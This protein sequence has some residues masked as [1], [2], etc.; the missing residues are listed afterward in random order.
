MLLLCSERNERLGLCVY[1][2]ASCIYRYPSLLNELSWKVLNMSQKI[3][4]VDDD[5]MI[6]QMMS[7]LLTGEGYEVIS[8]STALTDFE[9][10]REVRPNLII[11][12]FMMYGKSVGFSLIEKLKLQKDLASIPL[13]VCTG[14]VKEVG[15]LEGQLKTKGVRLLLKPFDI[16]DL[17]EA[18]HQMLAAAAYEPTA[19][20]SVAK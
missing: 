5:Q 15:A 10:V 17:L 3:M 7:E 14:A 6:S 1:A 12:D 8:R 13:I 20:Y 18:A 16:D 2:A 9:Q 19:Q 4:V 11:L